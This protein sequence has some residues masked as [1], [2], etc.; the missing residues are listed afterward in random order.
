MNNRLTLLNKSAPFTA[1]NPSPL[2][3]D[4][5]LRFPHFGTPEQGYLAVAEGNQTCPFPIAR[6][7]WVY[8]CPNGQQ[9]GGHAHHQHHQLLVC[10]SG[11]VEVLLTDGYEQ[12]IFV[13]NDPTVGLYQKPL[14]W[15]DL[16]HRNNSALVVL[17]SHPYS[18]ADYIR[19]FD[20]FLKIVA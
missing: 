19:N 10:V 6:T 12:K 14:L 7:Y 15:G 2:H 5:I 3:D 18:E 13:L 11:E 9:R 8:G 1:R 16:V 20:D 17:A 4:L